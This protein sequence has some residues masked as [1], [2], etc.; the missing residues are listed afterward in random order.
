MCGVFAVFGKK[1]I[2]DSIY[3][4]II[5]LQHRGQDAAGIYLYDQDAD[6]YHL[7][8]NL[9]LVTD[10]L[11]TD[12]FPLPN[13]TWGLGH[14]R[15]S[16]IGKGKIE[17]AQPL[18]HV[19]NQK[20]AMAHN[21]NVVNYVPLRKELENRGYSFQSSCDVEVILRIFTDNLPDKEL[22][23]ESI[24][25]AVK[26]VHNKII[27][28]YSLVAIIQGFGMVA[29]RDPQGIRPLLFGVDNLEPSFAF[30]SETNAL[31]VLGYKNISDVKSGEVVFIDKRGKVQKKVVTCAGYA[32]CSFEFNYFSKP[33]TIHEN[34]EVYK[35][36]ALLG[37]FLAEKITEA[38][39]D[40]DAVIPIPT[41]ARS[42]AI[43]LARF[44]GVHYEE[45][46]VKQDYIGRTFIMPTQVVRQK[47]VSR[48]LAAVKS[49]FKGKKVILV[50]D[51]I[52]RGTVSKRV[53]K[54]ARESGAEKVYFASTFPPITHP[55][56]YGID[57]PH[58]DQLIAK[59]NSIDLISKEIG[60]DGLFYNNVDDLKTAI[61]KDTI[62]TACVSGCYPTEVHGKEELQELRQ[63]D[64]DEL[65]QACLK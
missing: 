59:T 20:V 38:N 34:R 36:R 10:V 12:S 64:L 41:T 28:A 1:A 51:S 46:F 19:K 49:V 14:V 7:H 53:V 47:A 25:R 45:G 4:G 56:L 21:G 30:A 3:H 32:H 37:K 61:G 8:K 9:G 15:Y 65:E 31:N 16:T 57:F 55:C 18:F 17:D 63:R 39:I 40:L 29:F 42:S 26:A 27:G 11:K 2:S 23:F 6:K 35:T 33:N 58:S 24:C 62:C 48:K 50:D 60:V 54:L 13:A 5:Q 22:C 52:V 43:A 44:L